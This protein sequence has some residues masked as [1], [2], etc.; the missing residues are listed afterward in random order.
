MEFCFLCHHKTKKRSTC[1]RRWTRLRLHTTLPGAIADKWWRVAASQETSTRRKQW[2]RSK[3][4]GY[5]SPVTGVLKS[6]TWYNS[7]QHYNKLWFYNIA[8]R[9]NFGFSW[10]THVPKENQVTYLGGI[11][12]KEAKGHAEVEQRIAAT[13]ATWK[14]MH[15]FFKDARCPIRWKLIVYDSMI[16]SKLLYGLETVELS[17]AL[18]TKL[19]TYQ[20][21][22]LRKILHMKPPF[23][24]RR[25]SNAEVYRRTREACESRY[26]QAS[27]LVWN[28]RQC[29]TEK[30]IKLT[31]H[32]LR[33]GASDP[34][35]QVSF[36]RNSATPYTPTCR[37][38]DLAK[39]GY[40][41]LWLC[42]G[43]N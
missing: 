13:M 11:I 40:S 35:R 6:R 12:T 43:T 41:P 30:R 3:W 26:N 5:I 19:E 32:I 29:T 17:P 20:I 15:L 18:L 33:S 9:A 38:L 28:I 21:K 8:C 22:G 2:K 25:N 36:R 4:L 7:S 23:I 42:V 37:R 31:G 27:S 24:D 1:C 16:P 34:M 14:K 39:T 10:I